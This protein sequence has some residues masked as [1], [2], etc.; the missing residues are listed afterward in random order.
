[1]EAPTCF[2]CYVLR[3]AKSGRH[4]IGHAQ[5]LQV[6]LAY[7][8]AGKVVATRG[9]GPWELVYSESYPTRIHASQR[10]RELKSWKTVP[11]L[12]NSIERIRASR[13][14]GRSLV[15]I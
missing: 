6:R 13:E 10:E 4:Y 5:D 12:G 15:R 14:A 2:F 9:K 8:N 7:H 3:S 11:E 1:L